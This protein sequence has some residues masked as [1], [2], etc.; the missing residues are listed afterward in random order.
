M[1]KQMRSEDA[2]PL[3]NSAFETGI[4]SIVVMDACFPNKFD[5]TYLS[6]LDHLVV[7]TEDIGGPQSIHPDI[8]QRT[9]ELLVR[10]RLIEEGLNFMRKLHLVETA[11]DDSGITFEV[12]E[13]ASA[14]VDSLQT[15]YAQNL[16]DRAVWLAK[17]LQDHDYDLSK[18]IDE[19]IGRWAIEFQTENDLPGLI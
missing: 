2:V 14:F 13:E 5:V 9:G 6:W 16:K 4:R 8:P 7:H 3:F 17:F 15:E 1:V 12:T 11:I 10:R 18:V 19:K